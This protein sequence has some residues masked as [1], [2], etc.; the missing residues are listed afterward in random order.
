MPKRTDIKSV[1]IIGAGPIVIGQACEF[2]YSGAQAC[3]A[4]RD[5]GYRVILV[6]SNPATIMTDP[7]MADVTY[8]E[9][10]TW[11]VVEAIIAK[12]RP[13]ALLPTM[14]GQT[15]A[16]LRARPRPARRA[17]EARRRDDRREPRGDRQGRGSRE[18]QG[19]DEA[20]RARLSALLARALDGRGA[21][22]AGRDRLP[23]GDPA[24]VHARRIGRRHRLQPRGVRRDLRARAR[25]L[26]DA[27]APD[28]GIGGRLERV[29]D[30]GGARP[31]RQLHHRLLDREPRSDGRAH[32][33]LDHR[34][35]GADAHR[36][37]VPA[38]A[39]RLDRGA[40]RDRRRHRRVERA[41]RGVARRRPHAG[42]RDESA[43]APVLGARFE[44][45]RVPDREGRG[46]A[47][48][49]LHARR[50]GERDHRR[51]D[52][53]VLR[54]DDRLRRHENP[55]LRVREVPARRQPPHHPDEVGGRGDGDRPHL[56]GVAPEGAAR[57]RGRRRRPGR[58]D[59]RPRDDRRRAP[60]CRTRPDLV[61]GR[62]FP[63]RSDARRGSRRD[64]HRSVVPRRDRGSG[65]P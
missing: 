45:D 18:V 46:E 63:L 31:S 10:V 9:P 8:V 59:H 19:R 21:A 58:E 42:D 23:G 37:G 25:R 64:P 29:R 12:E 38:D 13:D 54:A 49:W 33:R 7:E 57:S 55:A 26:A 3:K 40:A 17:R 6:N 2:D 1:L 65:R 50:A 62:C 44:G 16:Q 14:G 5:E 24:V 48:G 60:R 39:R 41:V 56:P 22:G 35:P 61:R 30:G 47:G 28:R 32:R 15:G 53:G 11:Q 20:H 34:R 36:Q 27:R 52:P 51:C 4:L 43:R